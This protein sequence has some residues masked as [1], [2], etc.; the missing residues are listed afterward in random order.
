MNHLEEEK[1]IHVLDQ[2]EI[3]DS[4]YNIQADMQQNNL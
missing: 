1:Y 3:P 4:W 2:K